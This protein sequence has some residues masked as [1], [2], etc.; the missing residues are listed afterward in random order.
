MKK[1]KKIII[2]VIWIGITFLYCWN[3]ADIGRSM[4]ALTNLALENYAEMMT[5][6]SGTTTD[7]EHI[8]GAI[9]DMWIYKNM[10][11]LSDTFKSDFKVI[12]VTTVIY[13]I[14]SIFCYHFA[15]HTDKKEYSKKPSNKIDEDKEE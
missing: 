14:A 1:I 10:H 9:G 11:D 4:G 6:Y 12:S 15:F 7:I 5:E 3:M 13:V 2:L 8:G